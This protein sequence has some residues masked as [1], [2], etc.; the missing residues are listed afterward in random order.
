[1]LW[2]RNKVSLLKSGSFNI[3]IC[4]VCV[5]HDDSS[6]Y[7]VNIFW[8]L[9]IFQYEMYSFSSENLYLQYQDKKEQ[10]WDHNRSLRFQKTACCVCSVRSLQYWLS[11]MIV[12]ELWFDTLNKMLTTTTKTHWTWVEKAVGMIT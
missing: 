12:D 11:F 3:L 6:I 2:A 5:R 7:S 8:G 10:V 9:T 4:P 1:M